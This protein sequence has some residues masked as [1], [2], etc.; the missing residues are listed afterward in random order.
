MNNFF[1]KIRIWIIISFSF[2][3]LQIKKFFPTIKLNTFTPFFTYSINQWLNQIPHHYIFFS[4]ASTRKLQ[5]LQTNDT[6]SYR[7]LR[8]LL[9]SR[10][11]DDT[12]FGGTFN[13]WLECLV[14][15][16]FNSIQKI[17][18]G[19]NASEC[20]D[21]CANIDGLDE[22]KLVWPVALV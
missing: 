5:D 15:N 10:K 1:L 14:N 22:R 16:C 8:T 4:D 20:W 21:N 7:F 19:T 9:A 13:F 17:D 18:V 3:T 11:V 2:F 6:F 12:N